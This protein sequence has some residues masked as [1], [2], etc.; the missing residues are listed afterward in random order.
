MEEATHPGRPAG[1]LPAAG[2][3][4]FRALL[5][6]LPE[7]IFEI[8][9]EGHFTY[10]NQAGLEK[11]GYTEEEVL[12]G[13]TAFQMVVPEQRERLSANM[14]RRLA[15][16]PPEFLEYT[17]QRKDGSTFV[18]LVHAEPTYLEGRPTGLQGFL[19]DISDRARV[20]QSL[21][22]SEGKYQALL[23]ATATGFVILDAQGRVLDANAEYVRMTGH[24]TLGEIV[25]RLV[26][27]WTAVYDRERYARV[28]RS[29]FEQGFAR[30]AQLDYVQPGGAVVP[31]EINAAVVEV[32]GAP[33]MISITRDISERKRLEMEML[34]SEKLRSVGVLAGG[35]AHDFNNILTAVLGNI[36]LLRES[37]HPEGPNAELLAEAEQAAL[38]ARD[39]TR[40]LLTFSR[41][42]APVRKKFRPGELVRESATLAL[43]GR[44][45]GCELR[46]AADLRPIEGDEGQIGQVLNN[47]VLNASQAMAGGGTVVVE[48]ANREVRESDHVP[49]VEGGYVTIAVADRGAGI[50]EEHR[51]RIF[52]PSFTTKQEGSGLGLAVSYAI[53][54]SHGGAIT[55]D[56]KLGQGSVF[57]VYLP[58]ATGGES[59]QPADLPGAVHGQGRVLV[60]DDEEMVRIIAAKIARSLG[61]EV[62]SAGDGREAIELWQRAREQG[63]PFQLVIMDLT[64]PGGMGGREAAQ[65]LLA[66]E[67][68]ARVVVSSGY[69]QDPVVANFREYGFRD[70]IAKPY[71]V[72]EISRVLARNIGP[73]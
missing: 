18:C 42:G 66:T 67:P 26:A 60:M 7:T 17:A 64:V 70:T 19:I 24:S 43:R 11:F 65:A 47:L 32:R 63:R 4:R 51:A 22:E 27:D 31:I 62:E 29:C 34:R 36:S 5:D 68:G 69:S 73:A 72:A 50:P 8:D 41:G 61:Y 21:R 23:E 46:I 13:L 15:G 39:L 20:E 48:V 25:G 55:V 52:D 1:V 58:A 71:S 30:N 33:Q 28:V 40:Q 2:E 35:I 53:V 37:L 57:T 38:R 49:V 16:G 56:S 12:Q 6:R 44:G 10:A 54:S 9:L 45:S 3:E 14:E 59:P